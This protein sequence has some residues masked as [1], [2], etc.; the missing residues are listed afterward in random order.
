[1]PMV[2]DHA[3]PSEVQSTAG[4]EWKESLSTS[5]RNDWPQV[6][7]PSLEKNCACWPL[8]EM[9]LQAPMILLVFCRL[10]AIADSLRGLVWAPEVRRSPPTVAARASAAIASSAEVGRRS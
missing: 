9:L 4:S 2:V 6:A 7:P 5:G 3:V 10:M 1:M 8:A